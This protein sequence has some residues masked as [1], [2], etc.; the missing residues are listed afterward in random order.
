MTL[1]MLH[2]K[3]TAEENSLE[4]RASLNRVRLR[5]PGILVV[6]RGNVSGPYPSVYVAR[7][8][9]RRSL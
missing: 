6:D 5:V 3:Q 7:K 9:A 2:E 1:Y 8:S 4:S